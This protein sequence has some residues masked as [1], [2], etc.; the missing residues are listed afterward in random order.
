M[1][2]AAPTLS[3]LSVLFVPAR[4]AHLLNLAATPIAA[5]P[6]TG[7]AFL[8]PRSPAI[9][10]PFS[11]PTAISHTSTPPSPPSGAR[12]SAHGELWAVAYNR[13]LHHA[14]RAPTLAQMTP[15]LSL[16]LLVPSPRTSSHAPCRP[17]MMA[18]G[19]G[20]PHGVLA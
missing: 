6:S 2:D 18:S 20:L 11:S 4:F 9:P 8:T 3:S 14:H 19:T 16:L 17:L 1:A 12:C 15:A 5:L 13:P 10:P 7:S